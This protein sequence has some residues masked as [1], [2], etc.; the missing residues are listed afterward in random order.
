VTPKK[1]HNINSQYHSFAGDLVLRVILLG[2]GGVIYV[3]YTLVPLKS[4]GLYSQRAKKFALILCSM[5]ISL[6]R[7]DILLS[8]L[9]TLKLIRR[10][11]LACLLA[12]LLILTDRPFLFW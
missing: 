5:L 2:A 12:T 11:L 10:G 8:I 4:L 6:C 9:L 3:P 1:T 7:S